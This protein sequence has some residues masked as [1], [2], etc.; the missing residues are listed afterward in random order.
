MT[1]L[2]T[3]GNKAAKRFLNRRGYHVVDVDNENNMVI[4]ET[5]DKD[6]LV[7]GNVLTRDEISEGFPDESKVVNNREDME[8]YAASYLKAND[9]DDIVVRFDIISILKLRNDRAFLR[10]HVNVFAVS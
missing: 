3:H 2:E 1:E 7:F 6:T 5:E 10:H 9:Y 4:F 8:K